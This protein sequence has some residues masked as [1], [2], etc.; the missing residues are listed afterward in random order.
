MIPQV[1]LLGTYTFNQAFSRR[2]FDQDFKMSTHLLLENIVLTT[3]LLI[4]EI[5][6]NC[7]N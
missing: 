5:I 3:L 1:L 2:R 6:M 4:K 7:D